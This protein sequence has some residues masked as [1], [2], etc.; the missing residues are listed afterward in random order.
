MRAYLEI[1]KLRLG[2]RLETRVSVPESALSTLIP[3]LTIQPLVGNAVKHGIATKPDA[4]SIA[5]MVSHIEEGLLVEVTD[6][7]AGFSPDA[8]DAP[9]GNGLGMENVRQRL[10]LCYGDQS[11]LSVRSGPFGTV[12]SFVVPA[13]VRSSDDLALPSAMPGRLP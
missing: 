1:E 11:D 9:L 3:V 4:G 5:V 13:A 6:T 12:V 10:R 2:D 7:G 8:V